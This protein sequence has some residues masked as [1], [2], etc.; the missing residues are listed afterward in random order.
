MSLTGFSLQPQKESSA[1]EDVVKKKN[2]FC[3]K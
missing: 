2:I 1:A 3:Y